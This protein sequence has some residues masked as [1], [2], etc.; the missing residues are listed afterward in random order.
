MPSPSAS[1]APAA[2]S[3]SVS[4]SDAH[5]ALNGSGGGTASDALPSPTVCQPPA[6]VSPE[7]PG[8]EVD[9]GL[10]DSDDDSDSNEGGHKAVLSDIPAPVG[11]GSGGCSPP[12][13]NSEQESGEDEDDDYADEDFDQ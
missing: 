6:H 4:N 7:Q 13:S 9:F 3:Q 12:A 10:A 5:T 1:P 8:L 2:A 11:G